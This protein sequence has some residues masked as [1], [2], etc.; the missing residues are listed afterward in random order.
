MAINYL[1]AGY[2]MVLME[3]YNISPTSSHQMF[4]SAV[5]RYLIWASLAALFLAVSS[6]F[7]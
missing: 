4:L 6:A 3:K 5:H 1:A 2:F 7:C